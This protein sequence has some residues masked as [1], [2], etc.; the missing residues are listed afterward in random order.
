M[1]SCEATGLFAAADDWRIRSPGDDSY[2]KLGFY[3]ARGVGEVLI[4]DEDRRP[5]LYRRR[6]DGAMTQVEQE[7]GS[8]RRDTLGCTFTCAPGPKLR[9]T[10]NGGTAEV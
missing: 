9:I 8:A 7:D 4:V 1:G 10:W 2:A 5:E 3:G 6:T